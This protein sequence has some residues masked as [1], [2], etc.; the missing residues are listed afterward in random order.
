M[1]RL[2]ADPFFD[3]KDPQHIAQLCAETIDDGHSV[4]TLVQ[5]L[6]APAQLQ[7]GELWA[8]DA[9]SVAQEH[10]ATAVSEAVLTSLAIDRRTAPAS[11]PDPGAPAVPTPVAPV[12]HGDTMLG[13]LADVMYVHRRAVLA[14]W[15]VVLAL[16]ALLATTSRGTFTAD[17][18]TPGSDSQRAGERLQAAFG[19]QSGESVDIVWTAEAGATSPAATERVD[20]LLTEASRAQGVVPGVTASTAEVSPDG[21]TAVVRLPLDRPAG[22]VEAATG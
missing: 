13:R 10:A 16:A 8:T 9:W 21:R 4:L 22:A 14:G 12:P 7:V 6:L 3:G 1:R 20:R 17:Y 11:A 5:R 19:G 15:L 18:G 2:P